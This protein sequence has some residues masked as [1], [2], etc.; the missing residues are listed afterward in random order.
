MSFM[1]FL[2]L[3]VKGNLYYEHYLTCMSG[4]VEQIGTKALGS[5]LGQL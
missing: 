4:G 2:C 5:I 1:L 3:V